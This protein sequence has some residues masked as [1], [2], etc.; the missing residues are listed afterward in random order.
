MPPITLS[1][2][3]SSPPG[4]SAWTSFFPPPKPWHILIS[5][6]SG[7]SHSDLLQ[8]AMLTLPPA[9]HMAP[10]FSSLGPAQGPLPLSRF[11][12]LIIFLSCT[13]SFSPQ[14]YPNSYLR[15]KVSYHDVLFPSL[16]I[17]GMLD[18][19]Y[20]QGRNHAGFFPPVCTQ[21]SCCPGQ[22]CTTKF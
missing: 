14:P 12:S 5:S 9:L 7:S 21:P 15:T 10:L 18:P 11:L 13:Y 2:T 22:L 6:V 20:P 16:L 19:R 8:G 1:I 17:G 4:L 3:S